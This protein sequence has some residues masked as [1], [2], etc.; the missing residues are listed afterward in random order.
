M[1][2]IELD[3]PLSERDAE[4]AVHRFLETCARAVDLYLDRADA[5][6]GFVPSDYGLAYR[7]LRS[8]KEQGLA[9]GRCF[10]EWGSGLGV[11][12]L[13]AAS[14]GFRAHGIEFDG[15]LV[16]RA[17]ALAQQHPRWPVEFAQGSFVPPGA[18]DLCGDVEEFAWLQPGGRDGWDL[19][20][21]DPDEVDVV[22]AYPWP[23]EES[24]LDEM[25]EGAAADGA[26]LVTFHG[27]EGMRVRR[28]RH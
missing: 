22:Y 17:R 2:L 25:F 5:E 23:G 13:L 16:A 10:C 18:E 20:E 27:R 15:E 19:L 28:K 12:T 1:P 4:P 26:L 11:V 8:V 21:L 3:S 7:A 6:P 9:P 24:V 14:L